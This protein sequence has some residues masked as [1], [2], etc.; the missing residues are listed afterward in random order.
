MQHGV[1]AT[2]PE[3]SGRAPTGITLAVVCAAQFMV[4]LDVSVVNVALPSIKDSL[5]FG[6]GDLQWVVN[7]YVLT[8]AGFLL[9]GG[10]LADLAGRRR[11]FLWVLLSSRCPVLSEVWLARP[12]CW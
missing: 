4:V 5:G 1:A 8:F 6:D 3:R 9:L 12:G 2:G 7:A 11:T 10:R